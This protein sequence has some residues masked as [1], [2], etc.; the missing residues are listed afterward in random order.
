LGAAAAIVVGIARNRPQHRSA[1]VVI[2]LGV[3][4]F[5]LGDITYDVL[6]KFLHEVDP[7]PSVADAFYLATYLFLAAGLILMVRAR[8]LRDGEGGAALDALIVTAGLGALSWIYL[9]QPYV[10]DADMTWFVK[11]TSI[12]YPLGDILLLCVLVRLV[13][14]GGTRG[15]SVRLLGLG[16]LGVLGADSVYGWIQLHGVWRWVG[17]PTWA[18]CSFTSAG[19]RP[20]CTRRC[21]T[22]RCSGPGGHVISAAS[23]SRSSARRRWSRRSLS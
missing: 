1:W 6:T 16:A 12:A 23:N 13:F 3:T 7:F 11:V 10:H 22:S 17:P 18:G 4:T 15:T 14:G 2:A 19:V 8:R 9:I 21:V 5:A 20:R